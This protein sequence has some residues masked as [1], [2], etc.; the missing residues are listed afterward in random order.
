MPGR[1]P[2]ASGTDEAARERLAC[3]RGNGETGKRAGRV[4]G[5][6]SAAQEG[7]PGPAH[8]QV[9]REQLSPAGRSRKAGSGWPR[10]LVGL[11][12]GEQCFQGPSEAGTGF[13]APFVMQAWFPGGGDPLLLSGVPSVFGVGGGGQLPAEWVS[14]PGLW[15]AVQR[16]RRGCWEGRPGPALAST[17]R[18]DRRAILGCGV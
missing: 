10:V 18:S 8:L 3:P 7:R 16:C 9:T 14:L 12:V 5:V 13:R 4:E 15:P 11:Q 17:R 6:H 2:P 1:Q